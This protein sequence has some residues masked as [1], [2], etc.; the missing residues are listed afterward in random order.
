MRHNLCQSPQLI[1][2]HELY[3]GPNSRFITLG[4]DIN[5]YD[6]I[7][8]FSHISNTSPGEMGEKYVQIK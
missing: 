8:N 1:F 7:S 6:V 3:L 2:I 4:R 5:Y